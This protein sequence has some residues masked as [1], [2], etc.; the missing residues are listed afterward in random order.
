MIVLYIIVY[1]KLNLIFLNIIFDRFSSVIIVL[2][3]D[4]IRIKLVLLMVMFEFELMVMFMLVV[5][6]VGLLLMLFFIMVIMVCLVEDLEFVFL[7]VLMV[8]WRYLIWLVFFVGRMLVMIWF[9]GILSCWV[10]VVVV[11]G[12]LLDSI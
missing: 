10:M 4:L 12:L 6:R 9:V 8:D 2:R 3:F 1:L 11:V 5:V 7:W